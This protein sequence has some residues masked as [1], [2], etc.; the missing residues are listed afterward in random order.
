MKEFREASEVVL[1]GQ[2]AITLFTTGDKF[3]CNNRGD[4]KTGNWR[5]SIARVEKIEKVIIYLR[6]EGET[7]GQIWLADFSD[8]EPS[9]QA[10]RRIIRFTKL[11]RVGV[12]QS[13]WPQFGNGGQN[14]LAYID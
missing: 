6:K 2:K 7:G 13:D 14:P 5:I 8:V 12:T 9:P 11:Q 4:G 3:T 1:P 10:G